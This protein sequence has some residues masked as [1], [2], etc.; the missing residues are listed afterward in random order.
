MSE[1]IGVEAPFCLPAGALDKQ[2]RAACPEYLPGIVVLAGILL[3]FVQDTP[4]A[5]RKTVRI[6]KATRGAGILKVIALVECV[7]FRLRRGHVRSALEPFNDRLYP[8]GRNLHIRIK[9]H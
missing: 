7:Y 4:A 8:L 6:Q 3:C 5:E 1:E 2:R 9:Q